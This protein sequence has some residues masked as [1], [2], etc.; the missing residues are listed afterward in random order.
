M[1]NETIYMQNYIKEVFNIVIELYKN[2][3]PKLIAEAFALNIDDVD[4]LNSQEVMKR[5]HDLQINYKMKIRI[6]NKY[7]IMICTIKDY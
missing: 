5:L 1:K 6:K 4:K 7:G 3:A 2:V